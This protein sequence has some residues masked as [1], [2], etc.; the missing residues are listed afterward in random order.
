MRDTAY[1]CRELLRYYGREGRLHPYLSLLSP[2][3]D[4]ASPIFEEPEKYGYELVTRKLSGHRELLLNP[5]WTDRLNYRTEWMD[6]AELGE[7][8]LETIGE[9]TGIK[10]DYGLIGREEGAAALR[11]YR[12]IG[13]LDARL[14]GKERPDP[15]D[16]PRIAMANSRHVHERSELEWPGR[17]IRPM[18]VV[19]AMLE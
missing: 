14:R 18:G 2:F 5:S 8:T 1:Y 17:G 10:M 16:I 15:E 12:L 9:L 11:R 7:V 6:R 13:E 3:V 4:P 19:K